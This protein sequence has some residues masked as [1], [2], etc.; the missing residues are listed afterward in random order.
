MNSCLSARTAFVALLMAVPLGAQGPTQAPLSPAAADSTTS[1][2]VVAGIPVI[3]RRSTSANVVTAD[4]YLLGGTRQTTDATAGIEPFLL[5]V[6]EQGTRH[7]S[8]TVLRHVMA[9]LGTSIA[10]DPTPDWTSI[11]VRA[12]PSTFDSTWDVLA[13]RLMYPT[14]DTTEVELLRTQYASAVRQRRDSPDA[15]LE[16]L[17][18]SVTYPHHPY[19]R[20][21]AGT[22]RSVAAIT[23]RQLRQYEATQMVRS[24]MLIVVVGNVDRPRVERLIQRTLAKLPPGTYTWTL[25]TPALPHPMA[26]VTD[27]RHLPTNYIL[28]HFQGPPATSPDYQALRVALAVLSGRLFAIIRDERNLSYAV[29]APFVE[30]AIGEGG[31]YVTTVAPDSVLTIMRHEVAQLQTNIVDPDALGRLVQQFITEYFLDNETNADQ[32]NFLARAELYRGDYRTAQGDRFVAELRH[33]N[34]FDIQ[35]VARQYMRDISFAY[36]G[37]T[38]KLSPAAVRGF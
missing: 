36:V 30:R 21:V 26:L 38:T 24:R 16:Y 12:T 4:V 19:G 3:L 10:I 7:Y 23:V 29:N 14:I 11:G 27:E 28:G 1:R 8:K 31:L 33:V 15:L 18:D 22:E 34:P 20:A 6:S 35:R 13:D 25:P 17:A 2:F 32:A 37:D 5:D 9:T